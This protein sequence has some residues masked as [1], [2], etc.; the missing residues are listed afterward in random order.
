MF[1]K[2]SKETNFYSKK[3][4]WGKLLNYKRTKTLLHYKCDNC[5]NK[6]IKIRNGKFNKDSLFE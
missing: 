4:R 2:E 3:S 6:F 1:I 5:S